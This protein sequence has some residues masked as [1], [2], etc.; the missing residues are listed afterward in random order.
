MKP[1]RETTYR[2]RM[3]RVLDHIDA[4]LDEPLDIARLSAVAAFSPFHF[5]RQFS[6]LFG[7][8]VGAYIRALQL[9]RAGA[10]LAFRPSETVTAIA[11]DAGYEGNE[12]FARALR[13]WLTQSPSALRSTPDWEAW[14]AA[15]APLTNVRRLH[16]TQEFTLNDVRIV[17]FPATPLVILPHRGSPARIG[18]SVRQ[19]IAWRRENRLPPSRAAT[20]NIFPDDPDEVP[21]EDFRLD[22]AVATS[23]APGPGME[24]GELPTGR[25]A[26]LRQTGSGDDLRAAF[27]FLYGEWL[28][29]SGEEA[30]DAPPFA[31]RVSFF[32]DVPEHEAI[33]DLYLPLK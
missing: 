14:Q 17:D 7:L 24:R 21:P 3:R 8:S 29:Q 30:R 19:L 27:A 5:Q 15:I 13:N 1:D 23:C 6:A 2:Q 16:M 18:D 26:V 31:Q 25:C 33:T 28:P 9:K 4:H 32:P 22:L 10:R 12:A 11:L 20:L